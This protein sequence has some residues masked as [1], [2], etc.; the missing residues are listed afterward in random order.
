MIQTGQPAP[1]FTLPDADMNE[2][3][4]KDYI[5]RRHVV[6]C[7]YPKDDTPGCTLEALEFSDMLSEFE[8]AGAEVM[9]ISRDNC[10]SHAAFRDKH[11][12][13]VRLL[14]D[15]D[16][17]VCRAYGVLRQVERDGKAFEVIARTTF[18]IDKDGIVRHVFED[19]KPK[20]HAEQVLVRV[21]DLAA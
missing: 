17:E 5:G 3:S 9:G 21:Q 19:V 13:A 10:M 18:V 20:G 11:G 4:L 14:A 7:F 1:D 12:L 8:K 15:V 2:V 6:L 16:G